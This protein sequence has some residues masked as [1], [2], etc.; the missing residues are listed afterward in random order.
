MTRRDRS[1]R[2]PRSR[3]QAPGSCGF[4]PVHGFQSGPGPLWQPPRRRRAVPVRVQ[5]AVLP[6]ASGNVLRAGVS[7]TSGSLVRRASAARQPSYGQ[8]AAGSLVRTPAADAAL[9]ATAAGTLVPAAAAAVPQN[10]AY[11]RPGASEPSGGYG[12]QQPATTSYGQPYGQRG[13]PRRSLSHASMGVNVPRGRLRPR[14]VRAIRAP[15]RAR[16]VR[17]VRINYR[18]APIHPRS[19]RRRGA[20]AGAGFSCC[21]RSPSSSGCP[22]RS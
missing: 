21:F 2:L 16:P 6:A 15:T 8:R 14:T 18:P 10:P 9:P 5:I 17:T 11:Y 12:Q 13:Y 7:A 19:P 3:W 22:S 20:A 1:G 4:L